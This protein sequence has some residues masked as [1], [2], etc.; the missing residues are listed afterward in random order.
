MTIQESAKNGSYLKL[1]GRRLECIQSVDFNPT[2]LC[3]GRDRYGPVLCGIEF[4]AV[5][6]SGRPF[7]PYGI[8]RR[9]RPTPDQKRYEGAQPRQKA[10]D[11]GR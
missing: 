10:C 11:L 9:F 8:V 7:Y 3:A 2:D 6:V 4:I 1:A 5:T